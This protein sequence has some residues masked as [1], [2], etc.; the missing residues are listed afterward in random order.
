MEYKV[1][2]AGSQ[3]GNF[4]AGESSHAVGDCGDNLALVQLQNPHHSLR[5]TAYE[6]MLR[7]RCLWYLHKIHGSILLAYRW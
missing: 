4:L 1:A 6:F 2:P 3:P 7:V 5:M